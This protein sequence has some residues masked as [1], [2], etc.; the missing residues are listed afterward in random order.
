MAEPHSPTSHTDAEV[1]HREI[2]PGDALVVYTDGITER[3]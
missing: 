2:G 3:H 1:E